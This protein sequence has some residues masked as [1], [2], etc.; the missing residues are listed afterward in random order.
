MSTIY[1]DGFLYDALFGHDEG[2]EFYLA[3]ATQHPGPVL[4][5]GA[6]TGRIAIPLAKRGFS[7]TAVDLSGSML[8]TGEEKAA[9]EGVTIAWAE[10][11]FRS[12]RPPIPQS[13]IY[14]VNNWLLHL[15]TRDDI[16]R[17]LR[18][19][20]ESLAEGGCF[21]FDVFNPSLSLHSQDSTRGP[22]SR[23]FQIREQAL[24]SVLNYRGG[25]TVRFR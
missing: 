1:D 20:R 18:C 15:H 13:L 6:G 10:G 4:E 19:I 17:A 21:A 24:G 12:Y 9:E 23:P 14:V 2:I 7:V 25:T 3:L 22:R 5:L 16:E 11:D 8:E